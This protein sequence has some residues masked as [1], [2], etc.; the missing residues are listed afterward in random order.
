MTRKL[1]LA[2]GIVWV[3]GALY[4]GSPTIAA[5]A[6]GTHVIFFGLHAIEV[7]LN[8]LLDHH[9]IRVTDRDLAE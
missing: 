6:A 9:G 7:R 3:G 5:I 8:K 1:I 2:S 4:Y